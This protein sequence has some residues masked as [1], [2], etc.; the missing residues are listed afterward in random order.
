MDVPELRKHELFA[1]V[2]LLLFVHKFLVFYF[3]RSQ[4]DG[5][6]WGKEGRVRGGEGRGN[7]DVWD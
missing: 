7:L 3:F 1:S 6:Q 4:K 5:C 2:G